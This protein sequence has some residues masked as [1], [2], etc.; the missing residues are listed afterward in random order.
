MS[1][2]LRVKAVRTVPPKVLPQLPSQS[3]N[4]LKCGFTI[5]DS[6]K[7]QG[8]NF[9]V[10]NREKNNSIPATNKIIVP[11]NGS[12]N[13]DIASPKFGAPIDNPMCKTDKIQNTILEKRHLTQDRIRFFNNIR[14]GSSASNKSGGQTAMANVPSVFP[15]KGPENCNGMDENCSALIKPKNINEDEDE[16]SGFCLDSPTEEEREFFIS[17][18]WREEDAEKEESLTAKEIDDFFKKVIVDVFS[19]VASIFSVILR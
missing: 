6:P 19:L 17:L 11:Q 8:G 14:N 12:I 2:R 7:H 9:H 1:D 10:L 3:A 4:N 13:S 5:S 16:Q 18:G 15:T